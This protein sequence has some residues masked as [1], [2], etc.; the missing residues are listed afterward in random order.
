MVLV[1]VAAEIVVVVA[2]ETAVEVVAVETVVAVV[3]VVI[4]SF[5]DDTEAFVGQWVSI[6]T[7]D[8]V[9]QQRIAMS[10]PPKH[11]EPTR[12]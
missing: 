8:G 9:V 7:V 12:Y 4:I 1:Q 11:I 2:V 6:G 10:Y 5:V 3:V